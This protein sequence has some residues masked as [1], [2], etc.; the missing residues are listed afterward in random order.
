MLFSK[1]LTHCFP[2]TYGIEFLFYLFFII[3][4]RSIILC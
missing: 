1:F 2:S 3:F 4:F